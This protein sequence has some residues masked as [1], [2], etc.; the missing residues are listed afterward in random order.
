MTELFKSAGQPGEATQPLLGALREVVI[1]TPPHQFRLIDVIG[2][3][4]VFYGNELDNGKSSKIGGITHIDQLVT[5]LSQ[6]NLRLIKQIRSSMG[7][8]GR[9]AGGDRWRWRSRRHPRRRILRRV[10]R[11]VMP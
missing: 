6:Q 10:D 8:L 2:N 4:I 5:T 7:L 11:R 9:H 3:R 1:R